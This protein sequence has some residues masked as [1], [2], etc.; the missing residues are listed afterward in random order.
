MYPYA[1]TLSYGLN[2]T[3][4]RRYQG[5]EIMLFAPTLEVAET[6]APMLVA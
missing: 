6:H 1:Q 4:Q 3:A 5:A 2:Y